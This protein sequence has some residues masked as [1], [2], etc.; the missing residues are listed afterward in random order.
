[1]DTRSV[2]HIHREKGRIAE[3][4]G[5]GYD[6]V[7][8]ETAIGEIEKGDWKYLVSPDENEIFVVE[9]R[10]GKYLRTHPNPLRNLGDLPEPTEPKARLGTRIVTRVHREGGVIAELFGSDWGPCHKTS[11]ID[12]IE[13]HDWQ[14]M[15][16]DPRGLNPIRV[17]RPKKYGSYLRTPP[18]PLRNLG[19]LSEPAAH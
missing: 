13:R 8:S 5:P 18:N 15:V 3:L 19:E 16:D 17:V 10:Y 12:E 4:F 7:S 9:S 14:Y 11:A 1:M 2:T 6:S